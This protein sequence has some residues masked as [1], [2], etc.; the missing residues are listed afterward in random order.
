MVTH[1]TTNGFRDPRALAG[2]GGTFES[3]DLQRQLG[4][5]RRGQL[6]NERNDALHAGRHCRHR[7]SMVRPCR[8]VESR[9]FLD[10]RAVDRPD[11]VHPDRLV[12]F[13]MTMPE[14][15]RI[16]GVN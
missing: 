7:E 14:R 11:L 13:G 8:N 4:P 9:A 15:L 6:S 10:P 2:I 12:L 5:F 1:Y 3:L 16:G